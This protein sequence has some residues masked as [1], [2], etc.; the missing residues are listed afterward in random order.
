MSQFVKDD[1]VLRQYEAAL[2]ANGFDCASVFCSLS[3]DQLEDMFEMCHIVKPGHRFYIANIITRRRGGEEDGVD[4]SE[5]AGA[6][7]VS[8]RG[9]LFGRGGATRANSPSPSTKPKALSI[10]RGLLLEGPQEQHQSQSR[11]IPEEREGYE[12]DA[13]GEGSEEVAVQKEMQSKPFEMLH[14]PLA[15]IT[16][17]AQ[18]RKRKDA[19]AS[20]PIVTLRKKNSSNIATTP[21]PAHAARPRNP[22]FSAKSVTKEK[23]TVL[24]TDN[25]STTM[26]LSA[27]QASPSAVKKRQQQQLAVTPTN[28]QLADRQQRQQQNTATKQSAPLTP[29]EPHSS[30]PYKTLISMLRNGGADVDKKRVTEQSTLTS[31]LSPPTA[32]TAIAGGSPAGTQAAKEFASLVLPTSPRYE[33]PFPSNA[34]ARSPPLL[35]RVRG[36]QQLSSPGRRRLRPSPT[37]NVALSAT[38]GARGGGSPNR[39]RV[40]MRDD[41]TY[42]YPPAISGSSVLGT[43][44]LRV[45]SPMRHHMYR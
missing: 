14:D 5:D 42:Y 43:S 25:K 15:S 34:S 11:E 28:S 23:Q 45:D 40:A 8:P 13:N 31:P 33:D 12:E 36:D 9:S 19:G 37:R 7:S 24:P 20:S 39:S 22:Y 3:P 44:P 1:E 21:L 41:T 29:F 2:V 32:T 35:Q 6:G 10:A 17:S 30:S 26:K 27:R 18:R 4:M 16:E 38:P